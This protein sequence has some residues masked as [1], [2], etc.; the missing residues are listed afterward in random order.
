MICS[1][2]NLKQVIKDLPDNTVILVPGPDYTYRPP[3]AHVANVIQD[4]P[5]KWSSVRPGHMEP[6]V[7]A[8]VLG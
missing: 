8:L 6:Q 7:R 2:G 5:F 3:N 4:A 1:V